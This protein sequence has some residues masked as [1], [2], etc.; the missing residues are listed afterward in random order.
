[1]VDGDRSR[2]KLDLFGHWALVLGFPHHFG[3]NWDAFADS[4]RDFLESGTA[5][6][7]ALTVLVRNAGLLLIDA[8]DSELGTLV[9]I[10]DSA[11]CD[12][13]DAA[14]AGIHI[15]L[16]DDEAALIALRHRLKDNNMG[17]R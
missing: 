11:I 12:N 1:V 5:D 15:E 4:F 6:G 2:T 17:E 9:E 16:N 14:N 10:L 13:T 8:P 7:S 3:G